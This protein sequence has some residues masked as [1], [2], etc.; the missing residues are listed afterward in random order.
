MLFRSRRLRARLDAA[1]LSGRVTWSPNISRE[2]K[3]SFLRGLS[4]FSVPATYAE[5]FGLYVVEAMA[6]GV[7]VVQPESAA[8]PE[9]IAAGGGGML[10]P[11]GDPVALARAWSKLL[12]DPARRTALGGA[13]RAAAESHF[14]SAAMAATFRRELAGLR[15]STSS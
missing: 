3:I 4:L 6:C 11:P 12:A 7:P 15:S 5:A 13:G 2:E 8:F 1:G 14:S 10:V 9:L